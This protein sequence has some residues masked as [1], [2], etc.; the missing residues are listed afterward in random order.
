MYDL[1]AKEWIIHC[2]V[3]TAVYVTPLG[4]GKGCG[5]NLTEL[6]LLYK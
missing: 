2:I 4:Q 1:V 3:L 6:L 5:R